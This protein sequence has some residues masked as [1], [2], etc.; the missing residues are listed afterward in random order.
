MRLPHPRCRPLLTRRLT[1][2]HHVPISVAIGIHRHCRWTTT[3][4][5]TVFPRKIHVSDVVL[6]AEQFL[7]VQRFRCVFT[8]FR[9]DWSD[10]QH[11]TPGG[12]RCHRG[13]RQSRR[14]LKRHRPLF[15]YP[16]VLLVGSTAVAEIIAITGIT[17]FD[18]AAAITFGTGSLIPE[19]VGPGRPILLVP[20]GR[21]PM[22]VT[23]AGTSAARSLRMVNRLGRRTQTDV[24][25]LK[26]THTHTQKRAAV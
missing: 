19:A 6:F 24:S 9:I 4:A 21:T 25:H 1:L 10:D 5:G 7:L 20:P 2:V 13:P 15:P 23:M 16:V 14:L 12:R 18:A 11:R 8:P 26:N 3:T 22:N 17:A